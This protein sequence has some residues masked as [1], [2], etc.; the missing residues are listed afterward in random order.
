MKKISGTLHK[1]KG[2]LRPTPPRDPQLASLYRQ[3][4]QLRPA[5][6]LARPIESARY[7]VLDTETTG[8]HVYGGDEII[9]I[10][11]LEY[12]GLQATGAEYVRLINPG[13]SIPSESSKIH[14]LV[15]ADVADAPPIQALLPEIVGFIDD[16][17]LV[18]H[19]INF[20]LRFLNRYLQQAIGCQFRNPWL[21]TMLL[22]TGYTGRIGHY[23]L[24]EVA[25]Y[26]QVAV[27][28]RHTA[29]GD[30][31]LAAHILAC[32]APRICRLDRPVKHLYEQQFASDPF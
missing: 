15:D 29:R 8:F 16:A 2:L 5:S 31:L 11:M 30:A 10:A 18:G 13:R 6:L 21:D 7:V 4:R 26:C 32:L 27:Q 20:D 24:E 19:H 17:I 9:S 3:C 23:E 14:G 1:L 28:D 25:D 12:R 22:Y